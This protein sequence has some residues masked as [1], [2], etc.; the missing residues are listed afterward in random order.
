MS[1]SSHIP[2]N[3]F[4]QNF[5]TP[6]ARAGQSG[7]QS[8]P[9]GI[10]RVTLSKSSAPKLM[11]MIGTL[12]DYDYAEQRIKYLTQRKKDLET[13]MTE[14]QADLNYLQ[15]YITEYNRDIAYYQKQ[16]SDE[17]YEKSKYQYQMNEI[18]RELERLKADYYN[19]E[20]DYVK[21]TIAE[22]MQT[23]EWEKSDVNSRIGTCQDKISTYAA[24]I[25]DLEYTMK[26]KKSDMEWK[27]KE[28]DSL[29]LEMG[30]VIDELRSYGVYI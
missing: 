13:G 25:S 24:K 17:Q 20:S 10:D 1:A 18:N 9:F 2:Q 23:K 22:K 11:G 28:I 4:N 16:I 27:V 30:R 5:S 7:D 3:F 14:K 15:S 29:K 6:Q 21:K 8:L 26:W 12:G 19:S